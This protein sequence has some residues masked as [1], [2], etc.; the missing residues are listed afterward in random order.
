M[1]VESFGNPRRFGRL[2][3]RVARTKPILALKSGTTASGQRAA[4]SH[5][6]ALAG[7]EVAVDALFHQAGVIRASSLEELIDVAALLAEPA[8]A[9]GPPRRGADERRW[10]RDPLR[11]RLRGGRV[12]PARPRRRDPL[13]ALRA[14]VPG[15][16]RREPGRH[17]RRRHR[18][19]VCVGAAAPPGGHAGR[20]RRRPLRPDGDRN[21][22]RGGGGDRSR[23]RGS[24]EREAGPRRR[25]ERGR[26]SASASPRGGAM[27]PPSPTRSRR[28]GRSGA[29]PSAPS[30]SASRTAPSLPSRASTATLPSASSS[31]RS[32]TATMSG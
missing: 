14:P 29:S 9:E 3:R 22:G 15:S 17:A 30:G 16:Q 5:T 27:S 11:R 13:G 10:S 20:R 19:D 1:Y 12:E 32:R 7:S 4:S 31:A 24:R 2:A 23:D 6:A 28:R 8:R 18:E 26:H 25:A 21:R